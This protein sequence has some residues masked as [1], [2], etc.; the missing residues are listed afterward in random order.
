MN[1][2]R[3]T[4]SDPPDGILLFLLTFYSSQKLK[5]TA[6]RPWLISHDELLGFIVTFALSENVHLSQL[7]EAKTYYLFWKKKKSGVCETAMALGPIKLNN[8]S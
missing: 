7:L 2:T 4:E 5:V 8:V 1:S 6:L 3:L